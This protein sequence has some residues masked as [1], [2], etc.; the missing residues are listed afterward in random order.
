MRA[1]WSVIGGLVAAC[2]VSGAA[3]GA[4]LGH[5]QKPTERTEQC[6][7]EGCHGGIL[8]HKY[9]HGPAAQQKCL[10]CHAYEEPREHRF[11][12]ASDRNQLCRDCHTLD[13][14]TVTHKPVKDGS[15]TGCHD[16][17]GSEFK[18]MLIG[19][20]AGG[21]CLT[22]HKQNF[23][24]KKFIHGPVNT[25]A[26]ILCHESHSSW[27]E[28]LLTEAPEKLCVGCHNELVPRGEQAR[29]V[30]QPVVEAKCTGCHDA[31]ASDIKFQ[32]REA[33]PGLC[34]SCHKETGKLLADSHVVH[35]ALKE[36]GG[37]VAC[38]AAHFSQLPKLQ[39]AV[40]PASCLSCH[41]KQL[42]ATDG[43]MIADIA[44]LLHDNPQQHGPIREGACTACHQP[45]AGEHFRLLS[46]EY[47]PEFY[48]AFKIDRYALCFNCHMP[49][50]VLKQQGTGLTR[51]RNGDV[52]LHWVHVNREKG[53]TC[54]ACHEVHASRHPFHIRDAVPF[55]TKGWML[56][57]RYQQTEAGG[58]CS[59]GCHDA[60][61]YDR[62]HPKDNPRG[63]SKTTTV[64]DESHE[65]TSGQT[66]LAR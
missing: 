6:V 28:K 2:G 15:C 1:L 36:E 30:H 66:S 60:K 39:K 10:A 22:C 43:R 40:Q 25:G 57:I 44:T 8:A 17:H 31:H 34:V 37:C 49:D 13:L 3:A 41:N 35:G 50:L 42:K 65:P 24:A 9:E 47:P 19:D 5:A 54:R 16:P 64:K 55:G 63:N 61:G 29:H 51:F 11:K 46:A 4:P 48:A 32:L 56:E 14:R 12:L 18:A 23:A 33:A 58:S 21:L 53:R 45:H 59:P 26:C 7:N 52:N 62:E 27:Q 20:P 38:H